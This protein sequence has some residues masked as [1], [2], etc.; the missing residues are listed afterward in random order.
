MSKKMISPVAILSYPNLFE[1]RGYQGSAPKYSAALIFPEGT[2]LKALKA[3]VL[4]VAKD[5]WGDKGAQVLKSMRDPAFR[6]GENKAG[7]PKGS[8]YISAK[9]TRQPGIVTREADRATGKPK[10]ISEDAATEPGGANEMYPGVQVKALLSVYASEGG[11]NKGVYFGLEGLQRWEDGE[12]LD[13]RAAVVDVFDGEMPDDADLA[14]LVDEDEE[15]I[16]EIL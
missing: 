4:A 6:D 13:G 14:D 11:G 12:R 15:G 10:L 9:S 7:Y 16:D 1:P 2:D 3:V 8:T 5:K